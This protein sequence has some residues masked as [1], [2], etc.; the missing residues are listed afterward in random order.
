MTNIVRLPLALRCSSL[1]RV[2]RCPG[3]ALPPRVRIDPYN[4][5]ASLGTAVHEALR[6][7]AESGRVPWA[8]LGQLAAR[9][10]V[11][12]TE[13]RMLAGAAAKLWTDVKDSFP[14]AVTEAAIEATFHG[15]RLTGH[16]DLLSLAARRARGGD[17]KS[18]R[19]DSDHSQQLRGYAALIHAAAPDPLDE[20]TMTALWLRT[21]EI[22]NYTMDRTDYARWQ[23][24]FR[25]RLT[26]WDGVTYHPGDDCQHCPRV[27]E[28]AHGRAY[29]QSAVAVVA[30]RQA[31]GEVECEI[32]RFT[33]DEL[34]GLLRK[35]AMVEA[36]AK[37]AREAIRQHVER[38]GGELTGTDDK[39]AIETR[40][41]REIDPL[42]AWPVLERAGFT[43]EDLAACVRMRASIIDQ[44]VASKTA[45]GKKG[46]A[47]KALNKEL[48]DAGAMTRAATAYLNVRRK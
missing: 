26:E 11:A 20:V 37:R 3:S 14:G 42:A 15:V 39:L 38:H 44:V 21:R 6:T 47:I 8:L 18:G 30:D 41:E 35:C 48:E 7:L 23:Q 43:D 32:E 28:C 2:F 13:L 34:I 19:K 25:E 46:E 33:P 4:P 12:E 40:A 5:A 10:G 22:E 29:L 9:Y 16:V 24:E 1:P 45:R 27:H 17:W 31:L 36:Y